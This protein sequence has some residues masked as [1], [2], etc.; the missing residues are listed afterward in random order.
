MDTAI[1]EWCLMLNTCTVIPFC[2]DSQSINNPLI[3]NKDYDRGEY[4]SIDPDDISYGYAA[5]PTDHN[6]ILVPKAHVA[7]VFFRYYNET[8]YA[9]I[10]RHMLQK[11][12]KSNVNAIDNIDGK[13]ETSEYI[14]SNKSDLIV[15]KVKHDTYR[16]VKECI[17][18]ELGI[19]KHNMEQYVEKYVANII[20]GQLNTN[21][22][23]ANKV[24]NIVKDVISS[25]AYGKRYGDIEYNVQS[26]IGQMVGKR[27]EEEVKKQLE[28]IKLTVGEKN[29]TRD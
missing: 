11:Q 22:F 25:T 4:W 18:N 17:I 5:D 3:N 2:D 9:A 10:A 16:A 13:E 24:E 14:P 29:D 28:S 8:R 26:A 23:L 20:K 12:S 6:F 21:N 19:N 1:G 7:D 15:L 27:I